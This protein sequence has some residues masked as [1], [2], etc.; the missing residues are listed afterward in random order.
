M[1]SDRSGR[2]RFCGAL[3]RANRR[4]HGSRM[5]RLT[6]TCAIAGG[7]PAGL[8]LGY[9]LA[10]AGIRVTVLENHGDFLRDFRGDTIHPSTLRV[11][12]RLGELD[13]F[14]ALPHTRFRRMSLVFGENPVPVVD[15][16]TLGP[17]T[18]FVAMMPQWDFLNYLTER[19]G[20]YP[21]F[22]LRMRT[23]AEALIEEGGRVT[24]LR[25]QGPEGPVELRADLVVAADGRSSE[26]R[27]ASGLP[28][29][30]LSAPIDVLWMRVSRDPEES[31]DSLGRVGGGMILVM[32]NRGDYWQMAS[33]VPKGGFDEVRERGLEAF[34]ARLA[35][36]TGF[37]TERVAEIRDWD[38]VKL[39]SVQVNRLERWWRPGFLAIGDAAHAMS[40]VGGVGINLAVQDAVAAANL[41][42][43][44]LRAGNL[45]DGDLAAVQR[46]RFWPTRLTQA[47][48]VLAQDRVIRPQLDSDDPR[49][50]LPLRLLA[51]FPVLRRFPARFVGLGLRPEL[52]VDAIVRPGQGDGAR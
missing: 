35:A 8:M 30:D 2:R 9:L 28:R 5:E 39:L 26:L 21:G 22:T 15:L 13:R 32:L 6:T 47:A 7:G 14:L 50:P 51:R 41:L 31:S 10:R 12:D 49:P 3:P 29:R 25:A 19:A 24:A 16:T 42:A 20:A 52:P 4:A 18:G 33:V 38:D 46:R 44:P 23:R 48:Q 34:R 45:S 1:L 17:E 36:A 11:M 37:S 27:V 40:P 43:G